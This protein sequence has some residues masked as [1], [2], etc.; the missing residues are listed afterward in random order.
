MATL[1]KI[2]EFDVGGGNIYRHMERLEQYFKANAV[3]PVSV[4]L[5]TGAVPF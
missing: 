1:G 5:L 4:K 2:E 3:D